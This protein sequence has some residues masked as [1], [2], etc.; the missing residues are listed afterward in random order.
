MNQFENQFNNM[1]L[2]NI[3]DDYH[4]ELNDFQNNNQINNEF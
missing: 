4:L 1:N 2:N 3:Q